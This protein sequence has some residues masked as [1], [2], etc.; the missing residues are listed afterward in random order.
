MDELQHQQQML[1]PEPHLSTSGSLPFLEP[2]PTIFQEK[3]NATSLPYRSLFFPSLNLA[4]VPT[5]PLFLSL[6]R[7]FFFPPP[8]DDVTGFDMDHCQRA[9]TWQTC[10]LYDSIMMWLF[11]LY[12]HSRFKYPPTHT[13]SH[14]HTLTH[15]FC[16][17]PGS[18]FSD[19]C[20]FRDFRETQNKTS[21]R[22]RTAEHI[23]H[24]FLINSYRD[25]SQ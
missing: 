8:Q 10:L 2:T 5:L 6:H 21:K 7:R 3:I 17:P 9:L 23:F 20:V 24:I 14:T 18:C 19:G 16:F 22:G 15:C 11:V 12:V 13:H 25:E 1:K 4:S